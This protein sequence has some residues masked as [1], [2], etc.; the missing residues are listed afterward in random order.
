MNLTKHIA[1][2]FRDLHVGDNW[3][4]VNLKDTLSDVTW[5]QAII[6][7]QSLN[8]IAELVYHMNYF[9]GAIVNVLEGEPL[10]AHDKYSFD[11][12]PIQCE[13]D[14]Q[15]LVDKI[16]ADAEKMASMIEQM[17]ENK[18]WEI[19]SEE[20]YG[21]YYRNITGVIEHSHYHSGQIVLIKKLIAGN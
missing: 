9:I 11:L 15:K 8:T 6:K 14:W 20:K 17:P 13:E 16:F 3:T 21:N 4:G 1:K 2:H 19:F 7:I 18:M 10:N 5:Q 12:P